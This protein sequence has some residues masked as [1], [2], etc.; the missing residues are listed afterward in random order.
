MQEMNEEERPQTRACDGG[1]GLV[2][3]LQRGGG[4]GRTNE[5]K[6]KSLNICERIEGRQIIPD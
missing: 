1:G 4:R 5:R 2:K 6:K 3:P